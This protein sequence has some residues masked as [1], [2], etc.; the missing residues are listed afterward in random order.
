MSNGYGQL[1]HDIYEFQNSVR[2]LSQKMN[3]AGLE[4][5]DAKYEELR[6]CISR[7][8]ADSKEIQDKIAK[9]EDKLVRLQSAYRVIVMETD[10]CRIMKKS[11]YKEED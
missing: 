9:T 8:A 3:H 10:N 11:D 1:E 5:Q 7:L 2:E 6:Q 4:W